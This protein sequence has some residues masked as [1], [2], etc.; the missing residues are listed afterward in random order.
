M[1]SIASLEPQMYDL[2]FVVQGDVVSV[3]QPHLQ[4]RSL[5]P[6]T[7][8]LLHAGLIGLSS[9]LCRVT[10]TPRGMANHVRVEVLAEGFEWTRDKPVLL[11]R[12]SD[13]LSAASTPTSSLSPSSA[14]SSSPATRAKRRFVEQTRVGKSARTHC[15]DLSTCLAQSTDSPGMCETFQ[16]G[17]STHSSDIG[18]ITPLL[19]SPTLGLDLGPEL[20]CLAAAHETTGIGETGTGLPLL[21]DVLLGTSIELSP[22]LGDAERLL[23]AISGEG[24][25][26]ATLAL[27]AGD[28]LGGQVLA[29]LASLPPL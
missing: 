8:A 21:S 22:L 26:A 7:S 15:L 13:Q 2:N 23:A 25:L 5:A 16:R 19:C 4:L 28:G 6:E 29:D 10:N 27:V 9:V 11:R 24:D 18:A 20:A 17:L 12:S 3:T 1:S 14:R